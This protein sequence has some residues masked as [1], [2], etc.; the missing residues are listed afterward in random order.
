MTYSEDRLSPKLQE[1]IKRSFCPE[2][3]GVFFAGSTLSYEHR[4]AICS[5]RWVNQQW[6]PAD[7]PE[8]IAKQKIVDG[9]R[10]Q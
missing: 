6:V 10:N 8:A 2:C 3:G 5:M 9:L 4:D 1:L 7:S